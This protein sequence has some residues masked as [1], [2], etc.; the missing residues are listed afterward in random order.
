[1][2]TGEQIK[3]EWYNVVFTEAEHGG[4]IEGADQEFTC[5]PV[6]ALVTVGQKCIYHAGDTALIPSMYELSQKH[7]DLAFLPI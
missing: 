6:G 2:E 3:R 1:M 7:I 5:I 4:E